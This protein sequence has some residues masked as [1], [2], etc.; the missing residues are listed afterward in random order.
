M[1]ENPS[2]FFISKYKLNKNMIAK[3]TLGSSV[4]LILLYIMSLNKSDGSG[5]LG[6]ILSLCLR[7]ER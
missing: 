6:S 7:E 5:I 3:C 2:K 1:A 4:I